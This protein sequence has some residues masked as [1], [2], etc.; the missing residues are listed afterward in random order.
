V[1]VAGVALLML[2]RDETRPP[3]AARIRIRVMPLTPSPSPMVTQPAPR[4]EPPAVRADSSTS[5]ATPASPAAPTP[6]PSQAP[7]AITLP[8]IDWQAEMEAVARQRIEQEARR[9][10]EGQPLDSRPD[11][12]ALPQEPAPDQRVTVQP[13]GDIETRAKVRG[14]EIICMHTQPA[15]DEAFSPW[16]KHRPAK[17]RLKEDP[18]PSIDTDGLKPRYLRRPPGSRAGG[19]EAP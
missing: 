13:N 19:E 2:E 5:P 4:R 12:L 17:C 18:A 15:L 11:V 1:Q 6:A 10:R 14:G 9:A 3:A 7:G 16:A 8:Y